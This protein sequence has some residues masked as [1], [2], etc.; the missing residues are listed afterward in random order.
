[1]N[2][3]ES[4]IDLIVGANIVLTFGS[5][6]LVLEVVR[7]L[8]MGDSYV[9]AKGWRYL[10]PAILLMAVIRVYDF[11]T[12]YSIY[13]SSRLLQELLSLTINGFI[14]TGLLVQFLAIRSA[15]DKRM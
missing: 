6:F 1:M 2:R 11:F 4:F 12:Q 8:G 5:V 15:I 7:C 9:L 14:F 10:L 13:S 3:M